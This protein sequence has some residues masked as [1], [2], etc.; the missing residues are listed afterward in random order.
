MENND[1]INSEPFFKFEL[2]WDELNHRIQAK[3]CNN[4]EII[5][6]MIND[7]EMK[8]IH[9]RYINYN[10]MVNISMLSDMISRQNPNID[11]KLKNSF[12]ENIES[13]VWNIPI[14]NFKPDNIIPKQSEFEI[15]NITSTTTIVSNKK[16]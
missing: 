8:Y 7:P 15:S 12:I 1:G 3:R 4:D 13:L 2:Y 5:K 9:D 10:D 14:T 16:I 11:I 6:K